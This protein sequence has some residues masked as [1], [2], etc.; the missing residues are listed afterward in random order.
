MRARQWKARAIVIEIGRPPRIIVVAGQTIMRI[1]AGDMIRI[2][3]AL[4]IRLMTRKAIFRCA[5]ES[6]IDVTV[7]AFDRHMRPD[8]GKRRAIVIKR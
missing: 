2:R 6:P 5:R 4:K 7:G 3:G 1:I 8:Q